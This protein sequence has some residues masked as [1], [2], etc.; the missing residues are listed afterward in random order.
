MRSH[1]GKGRLLVL[2]GWAH[3]TTAL[4]TAILV[5][6]WRNGPC[7]VSITVLACVLVCIMSMP[8]PHQ[9]LLAISSHWQAML[10]SFLP[11]Q[12]A[13]MTPAFK[14]LRPFSGPCYTLSVT[15]NTYLEAYQATGTQVPIDADHAC[16]HD[17]S[18]MRMKGPTYADHSR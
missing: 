12:L 8:K 17:H 13:A 14:G 18:T 2:R 3:S 11:L 1:L 5:L 4:S 16:C 9:C 10:L 15:C 6:N 7:S